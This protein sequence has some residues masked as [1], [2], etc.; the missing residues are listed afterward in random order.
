MLQPS[1]QRALPPPRPDGAET[2]LGE[3]GVNLSGGQMARVNVARAAYAALFARVHVATRAR[4][5]RPFVVLLDD[6]LSAVDA[7]VQVALVWNLKELATLAQCGIL[8]ATHQTHLLSSADAVVY[9]NGSGRSPDA[10]ELYVG[11]PSGEVMYPEATR[12]M[13][14]AQ[15]LETALQSQDASLA[16]GGV[17]VACAGAV[18]STDLATMACAGHDIDDL[19]QLSCAPTRAELA[20]EEAPDTERSRFLKTYGSPSGASREIAIE[21]VR[22]RRS[23]LRSG[24]RAT[25]PSPVLSKA[26]GAPPALR[27]T[28]IRRS[29]PCRRRSRRSCEPSAAATAT[30]TRTRGRGPRV[31]RWRKTRPPGA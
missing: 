12:R 6:V 30:A 24:P 11:G 4:Q 9:L 27:S 14:E 17:A 3:R 20:A 5:S 18:A 26:S 21:M 25:R 22:V 10:H 8:L 15:A 16:C 19:A 13:S 7:K 2:F 29:P 1:F 23:V 28:N 31:C